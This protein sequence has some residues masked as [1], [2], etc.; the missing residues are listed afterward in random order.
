[1]TQASSLF[2]GMTSPIIGVAGLNA[3]I[4]ASY[5]GILRSF[6]PRRPSPEP[7]NPF[8]PS[9]FQVGAAGTGAGIACCLVSTPTEI[10]KIRAQVTATS[11]AGD[12]SWKVAKNIFLKRGLRVMRDAPGY[13]VYF[14]S[15]EGLKRFLDVTP[16]TTGGSNTWKLLAAG[17]VAGVMSWVSV[18]PL[19]VIKSRLQAQTPHSA[20]HLK[21]PSTG[22][23]VHRIIPTLA[24]L[25]TASSP[26]TPSATA[27]AY[28]G[29][30]TT[31]ASTFRPYTGIIDC[32]VRSYR[33]EGFRVFGRGI[34]PTVV[35]AFP[36]NSVTFFVYEAVMEALRV[37]EELEEI[38]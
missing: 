13:G 12:G 18:Y 10:V 20:K 19:D 11:A 35:R 23:S 2:K 29:S 16:G 30:A 15:Y 31:S 14:L 1:M 21:S 28:H 27:K 32:A 9:L 37:V 26:T 25:T 3:I 6:E 7:S 33:A 24:P 8:V 34:V 38:K 17:G 5:G 4:F 36:V 22:I